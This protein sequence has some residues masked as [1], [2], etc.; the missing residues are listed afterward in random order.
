MLK[1][2]YHHLFFDLD[3]TLWDFETNSRLTLQAM[4]KEF[5]LAEKG[6]SDFDKFYQIYSEHNHRLW[7]KYSSGLIKQDELRWKRMWH[8]LLDHKIGDDQLAKTISHR[9]LEV[10]PFQKALFEHT[11]EILD[12]LM[13]KGYI[14]HIISNGFEQ[15]QFDKLHHSG[16]KKYFSKIITSEGCNYVKPQKEIFEYAIGLAGAALPQCL[17]IGDNQEADI[18]GAANAGMDSVFVNHIKE[19]SK[20]QP[21]YTIHHLKELESIL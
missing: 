17:M 4:H 15:V 14:L 20:L 1:P 5:N 16:L 19:E 10:L 2:K 18:Q 6:I 11:V 3:H 8:T 9:Y 21:T 12:Y 13:N 7:N